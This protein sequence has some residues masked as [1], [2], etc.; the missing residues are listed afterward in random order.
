MEPIIDF[1][2][3]QEYSSVFQGLSAIGTFITAIV[4]LIT[5]G[6]IKKQIKNSHRPNMALSNKIFGTC[7]AVQGN[8]FRTVW[9][10]D[11]TEDEV[12]HSTLALRSLTSELVMLN[13]LSLLKLL[14]SKRQL[15]LSKSM[16]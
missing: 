9:L 11:V 2:N 7:K 1:F 12:T 8:K 5:I 4:T 15:G 10:D 13:K 14:I 3:N 16:T 6:L